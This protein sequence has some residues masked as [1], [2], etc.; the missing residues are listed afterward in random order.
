MKTTTHTLC[1]LL[2]QGPLSQRTCDVDGTER[3]ARAY[4]K[5]DN[6]KTDVKRAARHLC[7]HLRD[8]E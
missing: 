8:C 5:Y 7:D 3:R 1:E 2:P 4:T 6:P